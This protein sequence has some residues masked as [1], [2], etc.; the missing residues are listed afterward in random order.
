MLGFLVNFHDSFKD[1][2]MKDIF[3]RYIKIAYMIECE[4][5]ECQESIVLYKF[6]LKDV[7]PEEEYD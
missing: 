3:K 7:L 1:E 6:I 4:P 2:E 5:P